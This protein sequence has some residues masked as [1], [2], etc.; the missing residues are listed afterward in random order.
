MKIDYDDDDEDETV[1]CH[2]N[3]NL[4]I[5]L[6][7]LEQPKQLFSYSEQEKRSKIFIITP[8]ETAVLEQQ[9][10]SMRKRKWNCHI[11]GL[12]TS[13]NLRN[14]EQLHVFI[15]LKKVCVIV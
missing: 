12:N 1:N 4:S 11:V 7:Q 5:K 10:W 14:H 13:V 3:I 2:W 9:R 15:E 6:R 8:T